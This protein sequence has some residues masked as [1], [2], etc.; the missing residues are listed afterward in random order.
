[1]GQIVPC[2]VFLGFPLLVSRSSCSSWRL[3]MEQSSVC[4]ALSPEGGQL[5]VASAHFWVVPC[6]LLPPSWWVSG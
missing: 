3:D 4:S 2:G 1:M 5:L 6:I